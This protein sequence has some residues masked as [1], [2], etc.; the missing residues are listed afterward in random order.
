MQ[1]AELLKRGVRS[2]GMI[3]RQ[4]LLRL[5]IEEKQIHHFST[6]KPTALR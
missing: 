2:R 4:I 6:T 5:M 1:E 3:G